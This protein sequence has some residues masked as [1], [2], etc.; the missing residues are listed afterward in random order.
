MVPMFT[1]SPLV[2]W[3]GAVGAGV[4]LIMSLV[5]APAYAGTTAGTLAKA[6]KYPFAGYITPP[7]TIT[8]VDATVT[9]PSFACTR[10]TT[11]VAAIATV[12]DSA[13]AKFSGAEVYL[14]CS[15]RKQML[16]AL[17]DIDNVF[18]SLTVSMASGNTVALSATCGPSGISIT[19]DD[20]TTASSGSDS[21]SSPETCT[22]AE[23]GDDG[24]SKGTGSAVVPLPPFGALDYTGV[25]VNGSAIG[26]SSPGVAN[27]T[28]GKKNV[29]TTGALTSGGTAFTTTQEP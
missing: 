9:L 19:V 18:T 2:A 29:I 13:G 27:Y 12:Y 25:M 26:S 10:K 3:V 28:E 1:R 6:S 8:S 24:V 15:G 4:V 14:G 17:A 11:A 16:V 23:A 22:Q 20:E 7:T 21:S 5:A